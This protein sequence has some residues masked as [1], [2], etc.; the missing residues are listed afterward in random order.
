[1][2]RAFDRT[3]EKYSNG[4]C[5]CAYSLRG[6]PVTGSYGQY[7]TVEP[8]SGI[9]CM[10]AF[11]VSPRSSRRSTMFGPSNMCGVEL[12]LAIWPGVSS[13]VSVASPEP[14]TNSSGGHVTSDPARQS[15][16]IPW[17]EPEIADR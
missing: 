7:S 5:F 4:L 6:A 2:R 11:Q 16:Q 10:Y 12:E 1:M 3:S 14:G 9:D 17:N 8:A 15:S 13:S